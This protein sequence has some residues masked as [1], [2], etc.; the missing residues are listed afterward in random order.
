V[1]APKA[2]AFSQLKAR[3]VVDLT[4]AATGDWALPRRATH[5][6]HPPPWYNEP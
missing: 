5:E 2:D 6:E 1:A 3:I 4:S